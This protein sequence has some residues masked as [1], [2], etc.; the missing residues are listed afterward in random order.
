MREVEAQAA[1]FHHAAGLLDMR[2]QH[3]PQRGV[4]QVR[5]GVVAARGIAQVRG[6]FGAQHIAH[7]DGRVRHD[8]VD[9]QA[10]NA[11]ENGFHIGDPFIA[12]A[13][14]SAP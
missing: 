11:G 6:H 4:Q 9:G 8:A 2:A 5:G 1:R 13:E 10:G 12:E 3:L 14:Y 7:A